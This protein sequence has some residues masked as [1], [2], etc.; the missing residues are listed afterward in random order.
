MTVSAAERVQCSEHTFYAKI[1]RKQ[2]VNKG[3]L[4][5]VQ[6]NL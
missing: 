6:I 1:A 5:A 4:T 2:A 3:K